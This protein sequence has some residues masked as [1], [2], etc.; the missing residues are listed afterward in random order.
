VAEVRMTAVG[1]PA[2]SALI[3]MLLATAEPFTAT[4]ALSLP[5]LAVS[6]GCASLALLGAV[7]VRRVTRM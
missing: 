2:L 4:A 3:A 5:L 7:L 6:A 1:I